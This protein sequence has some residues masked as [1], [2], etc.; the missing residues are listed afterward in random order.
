MALIRFLALTLLL[1]GCAKSPPLVSAL[2]T[3]ANYTSAEKAAINAERKTVSKCCPKTDAAMYDYGRLRDKVLDA[4]EIQQR[5][6]PKQPYYP[7][8]KT[9]LFGIFK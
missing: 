8:K 1:V 7:A 5:N 4:E 3:V 6:S 2:P 9:G